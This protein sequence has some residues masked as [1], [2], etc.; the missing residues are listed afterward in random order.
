MNLLRSPIISLC[1]ITL[2]FVSFTSYPSQVRA[3]FDRPINN[4]FIQ[5][6]QQAKQK[7]DFSTVGRP[8][9]TTRTPTTSRGTCPSTNPDLTALIPINNWGQTVAERPTFWFYVPYD[10]QQVS[11]GEFVLQEEVPG[12]QPK[13]IYEISF[14]LPKTPGL[15]SFKIPSTKPPLEIDKNYSWYFKLYCPPQDEPAADPKL[16]LPVL[17]K[18]S[19]QRVK[20]TPELESELKAATEPEYKVYTNHLIWYDALDNLT[21]LRITQPTTTKL[22]DEWTE[23]LSLKG[24]K[25]DDLDPEKLKQPIAGS[26]VVQE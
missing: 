24:V 2:A 6:S 13:L 20:P 25:G 22:T 8:S 10:S 7:P 19:V 26:V 15:V 18:G 11:S 23:L 5:R 9:P 3:Q 4:F 1:T 17:V 16:E 12:E 14:T 21:K